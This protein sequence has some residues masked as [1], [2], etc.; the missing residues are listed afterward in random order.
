MVDA[1]SKPAR[2]SASAAASGTATDGGPQPDALVEET[3]KKAAVAWVTV[4]G[5]APMAL[6]CTPVSGQL[7]VVSGP[8][9]QA[10]PG[11]DTAGTVAV[12]LRGDHGG[13]VV[14]WP[15]EVTRVLPESEEWTTVAPQLAGKRLNASG[16]AETVVARWATT[17]AVHRLT[18][19][20]KPLEAGPTLPDTTQATP[21]RDTPAVRVVR[22]PFRLHRVRRR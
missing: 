18:P 8:D 17:C 16:T 6:W 21:V 22:K 12:T 10:A 3:V 19:A 11:L 13:R 15:A 2:P 9:E 14:T 5:G 20:G 7:Y 1:E 4:P